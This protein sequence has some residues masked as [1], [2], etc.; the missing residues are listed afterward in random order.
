[1]LL[2][3][4]SI[5]NI[6][7]AM[8]GIFLKQTT[9]VGDNLLNYPLN[10]F[11][12]ERLN[13]WQSEMEYIHSARKSIAAN[14]STHIHSFTIWAQLS[15]KKTVIYIVLYCEFH[16]A[17]TSSLQIYENKYSHALKLILQ[18]AS[19]ETFWCW[20]RHIPSQLGW[21]PSPFCDL[22]GIP[23]LWLQ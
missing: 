1:M 6:S 20:S 14:T 16:I 4:H 13:K 10:R 17:R 22:N 12:L 3:S 15:E 7:Y 2:V 5:I 11:R 18:L 8:H 9:C 19:L 21:C 23:L